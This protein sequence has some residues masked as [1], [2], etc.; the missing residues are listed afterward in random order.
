M[1]KKPLPD[2]PENLIHN[3]LATQQNCRSIH[4]LGG[5]YALIVVLHFLPMKNLIKLNPASFILG[6]ILGGV[7]IFTVA[8][9]KAQTTEWSYR[10][11][12]DGLEYDSPGYY[13]QYLNKVA[14]NGWEVVSGQLF[15]PT[16]GTLVGAHV[17]VILRHSKK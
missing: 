5:N 13:E 17:Y 15:H 3:E 1:F 9:D 11:A 16:D 2:K 14:T 6:A 4:L 7:A 12:Y 8:A 10:A